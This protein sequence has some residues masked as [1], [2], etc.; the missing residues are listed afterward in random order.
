MPL[1]HSAPPRTPAPSALITD[2]LARL[3]PDQRRVVLAPSGP[4]L[5]L[6]GAGSG[7]TLT[8]AARI[9]YA[10]ATG[11]VPAR[12]VLALSFTARAAR[13]LRARIALLIGTDAPRGIECATHHAVCHRLLRRHAERIART[14]RFSVYEPADVTAILRRLLGPVSAGAPDADAV[15]DA[16]ARAKEGLLTP[17]ELRAHARDDQ[18]LL[19]ADA[20]E[21]L[22]AE[23]E[24]SDA[25]DFD[26]L[27]T[28]SARL[29]R[30]DPAVLADA[31]DRWRFVLVDEFQ[32]TNRP[33]WAWLELVAGA[34]PDL[35]VMGDD[36]QAVY[37]WRGGAV[38]TILEVDRRV[39]GTRVRV[40]GR[41]YRSSGA[42]VCAAARLIE[43]NPER[44]PKRLWTPN[45]PGAPIARCAFADDEHEARAVAAWCSGQVRAGTKPDEVAVLF[46]VR[47]LA[48]P[49]A[50]ALLA[51]GVPHRILGGRELLAHAELRD[52]LA[53]L[54]LLANPRDRDA[55][56][57][58]AGTLPGV[59]PKAID[60][61]LDRPGDPLTATA[62]HAHA[63]AGIAVRARRTLT[64]WSRAL[65]GLA[66]RELALPQF[67]AEAIRASGL[68]ERYGP[69]S[70]TSDPARLER[71][72]RLVRIA[73]EHAERDPQLDLGGF[74]A[75]LAL[76]A[77]EDAADSEPAPAGRVTLATVHAAKGLEWDAVW[78]CGLEEGTLPA[79]RAL[80]LGELAEERRLAYVALT[81]ARHEL[82]LSHAR[83]RAQRW[84]LQPS[85]FLAEALIG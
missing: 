71:L 55:F 75:A 32:D 3:D 59:G 64:D 19:I 30:D 77:G 26:D 63:V 15:A 61:L 65:L 83:H 74:L 13:E 20:W 16:I 17:A 84:D 70:S 72:R 27:L 10:I 6:A 9:A 1:D 39:P 49:L 50:A 78:V 40:L 58:A 7:K 48:T 53:H 4:L 31:R 62:E 42:I 46:R 80:A 57:R 25:L 11:R 22:E 34:R 56:R 73:R 21:A 35:T 18:T 85:R 47:R 38:G 43:V 82:V 76:A 67:V 68:A 60:R 36:D 2:L 8:L 45:P 33:Q 69:E 14:P 52:A 66:E 44:R 79:E 5:V 29:L 37:S 41:N 81:R 24:R 51:A 28:R 23:L 12:H 54:R